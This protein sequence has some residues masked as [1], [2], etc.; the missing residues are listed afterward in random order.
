MKITEANKILDMAEG[1]DWGNPLYKVQITRALLTVKLNN[2]RLRER[3]AK[4]G[5]YEVDEATGDVITSEQ[6]PDMSFEEAAA[7]YPEISDLIKQIE[8]KTKSDDERLNLYFDV[9]EAIRTSAK[10][11][12]MQ[13]YYAMINRHIEDIEYLLNESRKFEAAKGSMSEI[14][15]AVSIERLYWKQEISK[16]SRNYESIIFKPEKRKVAALTSLSYFLDEAAFK[17]VAQT[18]ET[19]KFQK[20]SR[21]RR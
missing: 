16:L 6:T 2:R 4:H 13:N 15:R 21:R 20:N 9:T 8:D 7:E 19:P 10:A 14:E 18:S 17:I 1:L 11:P 5:V 3:L 12:E